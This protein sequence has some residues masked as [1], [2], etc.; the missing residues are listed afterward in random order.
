MT[1]PMQQPAFWEIVLAQ[2]LGG[3]VVA[4]LVL[5][6]ERLLKYLAA[7]DNLKKARFAVLRELTTIRTMAR[8]AS[9][10]GEARYVLRP[11]RYSALCSLVQVSLEGLG[12]PDYEAALGTITDEIESFNAL[13]QQLTFESFGVSRAMG[14]HDERCDAIRRELSTAAERV[15]ESADAFTRLVQRQAGSKPAIGDA[16]PPALNPGP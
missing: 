12:R 2:A 4:F 9:N 1:D 8:S 3:A 10:P 14:D 13:A 5:V 6:V 11:L 7:R 15:I 16:D